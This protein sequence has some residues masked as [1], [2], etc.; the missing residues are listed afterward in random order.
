MQ[1][2]D[3][4]NKAVTDGCDGIET[5]K[6]S[7]PFVDTLSFMRDVVHMMVLDQFVETFW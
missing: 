4:Y 6:M 5:Q 2:M 7:H 1:F 3:K